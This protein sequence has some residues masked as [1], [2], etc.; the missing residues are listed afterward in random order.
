M[1]WIKLF[2]DFDSSNPEEILS[3]YEDIKSV[4][5]IIEDAD[6]SYEVK[7]KY[8]LKEYNYRTDRIEYN[9]YN[10]S[11]GLVTPK[12][13]GGKYL[14]INIEIYP[15]R[16]FS[17]SFDKEKYDNDVSNFF[18]LLKEHLDYLDT[19]SYGHTLYSANGHG[20]SMI[21]ISVTK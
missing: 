9:N 18:S 4:L 1:N 21:S 13:R 10:C 12:G 11:N 2:E 5:Y 17:E 7:L 19:D 6:D 15:F 8:R 14:G 16:E 20:F 3:L